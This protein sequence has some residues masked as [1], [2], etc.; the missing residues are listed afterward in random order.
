[1]IR[2]PDVVRWSKT[3]D[4]ENLPAHPARCAVINPFEEVF[5]QLETLGVAESVVVGLT[6]AD[7]EDPPGHDAERWRRLA[8]YAA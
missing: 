3:L 1:M 8:T 5:V 6:R 7:P 4:P 2:K